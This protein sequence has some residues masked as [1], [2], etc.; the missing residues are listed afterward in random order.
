MRDISSVVSPDRL[1]DR[2][3]EPAAAEASQLGGRDER[4]LVTLARDGDVEAF[5]RLVERY[6]AMVKS[7]AYASTLDASEAEDLCQEVF[8]AAWR[9]LAQFR[10]EAAF[11]TWLYRLAQNRCTDRARRCA[12]RPR[13]PL[14]P[15]ADEAGAS[16]GDADI[17]GARAVLEAAGRLPVEFRQAV[18]MRDIQGLSYEEIA[19]IQGVPVGT[20][21]SR[22]ANGRS[23]IA[24]AVSEV[25]DR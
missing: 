7:L 9:G 2:W 24:A 20:V 3:A 22:I 11:S 25:V 6:G 16:R 10:G 1:N 21:R 14:T 4:V 5:A 17:H 8:L 13:L 18:L 23:A 15:P 19:A 12:V